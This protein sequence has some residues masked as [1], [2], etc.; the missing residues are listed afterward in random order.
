MLLC[1]CVRHGEAGVR[2]YLPPYLLECRGGVATRSTLWIAGRPVNTVKRAR[3]VASQRSAQ[4]DETRRNTLDI[5]A[6]TRRSIRFRFQ[7]V[8]IATSTKW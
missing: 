7:Q 6:R 2:G 5:Y 8:V 3:A 4:L 1:G